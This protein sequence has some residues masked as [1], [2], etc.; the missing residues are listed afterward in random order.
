[1]NLPKVSDLKVGNKRILLRCDFDVP[2]MKKN[3]QVKVKDDTRIQ[4]ALTTINYLLNK[5]ARLVIIGHLGRPDGKRVKD[6][7]LKPI[8]ETL[9]SLLA[10]EIKVKFSPYLLGSRIKKILAA[11]LPGE[12]LVLENLRFY[13]EE[14]ENRLGF[15]KSLA[16]L[17]DF[18]INEAF[19]VSH[20]EHASIVGLPQFLPSALGHRFLQEV[21]V[22]AKIYQQ[23]KR[24]VIVILGGA[25][26]DKIVAGQILLGWADMV[27]VGGELVEINGIFEFAGHKKVMADLTKK[28]EDIALKSARKFAKIIKTAGTIIWSGPLGAYEDPR[29]LRGTEI[30]ARAVI[31][32]KAFSIVGGGDTEAALTKL[33]LVDKIDFISSGGGAMLTFFARQATLPGIEAIKAFNPPAG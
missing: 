26:K 30:I 25:K 22:L 11:T 14:E 13:P 18:F 29:Y 23:P 21:K 19:A 7:S 16:R 31:S 27:L 9:F 33:G 1:M 6:L 10:G 12:I 20:R 17:G 3:G 24:P 5:K 2:L 8:A 32:S 15:A 4:L 28:G